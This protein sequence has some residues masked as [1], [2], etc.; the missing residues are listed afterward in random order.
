MS[1]AVFGLL[2][3]PFVTLLDYATF[4]LGWLIVAVPLSLQV[5]LYGRKSIAKF[6]DF[7]VVLNRYPLGRVVFAGII[8]F[9]APYTSS[10]SPRVSEI[11]LDKC[12]VTM[13]DRPWLRNPFNSV[14]AIALS[15]LGELS[16]GLLMLTQFQHHPNI[17]GIPRR[18]DSS[19]MS[20]ARGLLTA[21]CHC[22]VSLEEYLKMHC[23]DDGSCELITTAEIYNQRNIMVAKTEV[24]WVLSYR[25]RNGVNQVEFS[26]GKAKNN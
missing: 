14:H 25:V 23:K 1:D 12:T 15:N 20:K 2:L 6:D 16:T 18:I 22:R 13:V 11:T 10:I 26:D 7:F 17:R 8:G 24:T 3:W 4:L 5:M 19:Y 21:T 9:Y